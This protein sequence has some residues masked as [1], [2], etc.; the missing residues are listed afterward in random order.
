MNR[1]P[2]RGRLLKRIAAATTVVCG[3]ALIAA[4]HTAAA[5]DTGACPVPGT[6]PMAA[7]IT[8][9]LEIAQECGVEI[10]VQSRSGPYETV[11]AT[12]EGQIHLV[13]TSGAVQQHQD[14]GVPDPTLALTSGTLAQTLSGTP[15]TLRYD[16]AA[17]P[18]FATEYSQLNWSGT[19]PVPTFSGT[20][21]VYDELAPGLDFIVEVGVSSAGLRFTA[22]SAEAWDALDT[23]IAT[24]GLTAGRGIL[25]GWHNNGDYT[26][27]QNWTTPLTVRDAEGTVTPVT[28]AI[29]SDRMLTLALPEGALADAAYPL[30][31]SAQWT[32]RNRAVNDWGSVTSSSP[33]QNLLRGEG[34]LDTPYFEAGGES[35]DAVVGPYCDK[36]T[37]PECTAP[38]QAASYWNFWLPLLAN[39]GDEP[40]SSFSFRFVTDSAVFRID[41]AEG[42]DCVA[43]ELRATAS[44]YPSTLWAER[45]ISGTA[46][47][48]TCEGGTATYDVSSA[49]TGI[50]EAFSDNPPYGLGMPESAR[51]ARFEGESARL[52]VYFDI[53]AYDFYMPGGCGTL[54][55]PLNR[56]W[57]ELVYGGFTANLWRPDLVEQH[58]TW[59]ATLVGSDPVVTSAPAE[60]V[61]GEAPKDS[62]PVDDGRHAV[63]YEFRDSAGTV[64][65]QFSC[66]Y[67]VN[68]QKPEFVDITVPPGPHFVGDVVP[69]EVTV[70][71]AGFPNGA[72]KLTIWCLGS[73]DCQP[74]EVVLTDTTTV[75]FAME[76]YTEGTN[77]WMLQMYDGFATHVVYSDEIQISASRNG[78]DYNRDRHQDLFAVRQSDGALMYYAGKGDGTFATG[79][80]KGTG[81]G[82]TDIVMSGDLTG[83]G[84]PDLL[85]RDTKSGY[86]YTYPG[87]GSGGFGTRIS[88]GSGWNRMGVLTSGGDFN[89]DGKNDLYA[90]GKVDGKLYFYPGLGDGRF[91]ARTAIGPGWGDI[92]TLT[93]I[94]LDD[95]DADLLARSQAEGEYFVY[96]GLGDGK[97]GARE[98]VT[99]VF[100]AGSLST[101]Q[102]HEI[103]AAGDYDENGTKEVMAIDALTGSL[104]A[105]S[106]D[107]LGNPVLPR[108]V[109]ATGWSGNRLPGVAVDRT[110]DYNGNATPDLVAR[111]T[112]TGVIYAY[113][114][115]G[116]GGFGPRIEWG[117]AMTGM[118]L[119]ETAGDLNGDGIPD[120]LTRVASTGTLYVMPGTGQGEFDY[121]RRI[122]VGTGWNAMSAVAAG[123]DFND[124]GKTDLFAREKSTGR[125]WFYPGKGNGS[126]GTRVNAGTG[127]NGMRDITAAGD[128][129]H[130]GHADLIAIRASDNCMYFYA[131]RGD[132]TLKTGVKKTCGWTGY[133]QI[134]SVGDFDS[135][136][137]IDWVA[138]RKSDG[139]L[140][141]YRGDGAGGYGSRLEIGASGWNAMH[142]A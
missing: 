15:F 106:F 57:P 128:L 102:Y 87:N 65:K 37:D 71:D 69:V 74:E 47:T 132:G 101:F 94:T 64:V 98:R 44:L 121:G 68:T 116:T 30:T 7:G 23:G 86:L 92:D 127:W 112:S 27:D 17:A 45:P 122:K 100:E 20:T 35:G 135:D 111:R 117:T 21:A 77:S 54:A 67:L 66:H 38:A 25:Q 72:S 61:N 83:D 39:P 13:A 91:G 142:I 90:T 40:S 136:G 93:A 48:G 78:W 130:D 134:A 14:A 49:I 110:Y 59:T 105:H 123:H 22:D 138:R 79:V 50:G 137:R 31:L 103:V 115:N 95:G 139:K 141:L 104:V 109:L 131:G 51:T 85:A 96:P 16:N 42:T 6:D 24:S 3:A 76:I 36:V 46:M 84:K 18:L 11:Y 60:V 55:Y 97:F 2:S 129:D 10:R 118:D 89:R 26:S 73:D 120:L 52:D 28:P 8:A 82:G 119:V 107:A 75:T 114:G 1:T 124:D 41:A 29:D 33:D 99:D 70:A 19:V 113:T 56:Y 12:P 34:G 43:P 80:S 88:V 5:Q 58:L 4:P 133:D 63:K 125:L 53:R 140:F 9:A 81:W 126:F 62:F 32:Q 108:R